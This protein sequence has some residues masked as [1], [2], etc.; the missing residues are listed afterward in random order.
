V[1]TLQFNLSLNIDVAEQEVQQSI[2]ASGTSLPPALQAPPIY[3][4]TNPATGA[5]SVSGAKA[6]PSGQVTP[7]GKTGHQP[8]R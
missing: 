5:R 3:S 7:A 2:N 4:K 1:I 8:V 6:R